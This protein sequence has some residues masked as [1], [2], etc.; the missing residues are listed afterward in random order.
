MLL[1]PMGIFHSSTTSC[2]K[3]CEAAP[4][5]ACLLHLWYNWRYIRAVC[6][7]LRDQGPSS[8]SVERHWVGPEEGVKLTAV[9]KS[10]CIIISLLST[11]VFQRHWLKRYMFH[12]T[13]SSS[14][15]S[16]CLVTLA[17]PKSIQLIP[18]FIQRSLWHS[19]IGWLFSSIP[20]P[21]PQQQ[22][23]AVA[24]PSGWHILQTHT[25]QCQVLA[26][27]NICL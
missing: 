25:C 19:I 14:A 27:S 17:L 26:T 9:D 23:R 7:G 21:V 6:T 15:P 10:G 20:W 3:A 1:G 5:P 24:A 13:T 18:W 2:L 8:L 16:F 22:P 11:Y 12:I 4:D